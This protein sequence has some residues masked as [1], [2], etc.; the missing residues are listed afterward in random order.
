MI[1]VRRGGATTDRAASSLGGDAFS[2]KK[3]RRAARLGET[4]GA[5]GILASAMGAR[6]PPPL[7]SYRPGGH[8][9]RDGV[10][11]DSRLLGACVPKVLGGP[12]WGPL[13]C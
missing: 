12:T 7:P 1:E 11:A 9:L 8:L 5:R 13:K 4:W 3:L 10:Q 2:W 6:A